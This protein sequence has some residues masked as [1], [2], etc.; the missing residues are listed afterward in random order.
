MWLQ[1]I[2][3]LV[4]AGYTAS[5]EAVVLERGAVG[6]RPTGRSRCSCGAPIPMYRNVP[7]ISWVAQRG[8]ARCCN[9]RIPVWYVATE[10]LTVATAMLGAWL[11]WPLVWI[12]GL[13][14]I[15]IASICHAWWFHH[16]LRRT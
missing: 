14:G 5:F 2:L 7:V 6:Q 11:T 3:M 1:L 8:R 12:G 15:A 10:G 4:F 16:T 9:G 13:I